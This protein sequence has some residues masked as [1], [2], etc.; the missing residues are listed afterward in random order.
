MSRPGRPRKG[1]VKDG[2]LKKERL[3][4]LK[5]LKEE[6]RENAGT[7]TSMFNSLFRS[8]RPIGC[9]CGECL[10]PLPSSREAQAILEANREAR[11]KIR[12]RTMVW[13][14]EGAENALSSRPGPS[15]EPQPGPSWEEQPGPSWEEQPIM[16]VEEQPVPNVAE[17]Q[18]P[19]CDP[20]TGPFWRPFEDAPGTIQSTSSSDLHSG[21]S[22]FLRPET[23]EDPLKIPLCV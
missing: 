5:G 12:P 1:V 21:S 17:P 7:M 19:G 8:G 15:W 20:S 10:I 11:P 23:E 16:V 2:V 3:R 18:V 22:W 9:F 14:T 4:Q 13:L 6:L